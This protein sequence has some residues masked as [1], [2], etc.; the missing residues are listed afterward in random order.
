MNSFSEFIFNSY[1]GSECQR[2]SRTI[3]CD[4][5]WQLPAVSKNVAKGPC[6]GGW[7]WGG[8]TQRLLTTTFQSVALIM[9]FCSHSLLKQQER[10]VCG[11]GRKSHSRQKWN[12]S[13]R[14]TARAKSSLTH[15]H[16]HARSLALLLLFTVDIAV[17]QFAVQKLLC[18]QLSL[19]A[20][21]V[22]KANSQANW[23]CL[24]I[25]MR[26]HKT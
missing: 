13:F 20:A 2:N 21:A 16:T 7:G 6:E 9:C 23:S 3:S 10:A 14:G 4:T 17:A 19:K 8:L 12:N 18:A 26:E 25:S 1:V 5:K 11:T 24:S 15:S 22:K